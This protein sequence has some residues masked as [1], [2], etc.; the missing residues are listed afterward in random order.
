MKFYFISLLETLKNSLITGLSIFM[1]FIAPIGDLLFFITLLVASDFVTGIIAAK[2]KGE[3]RTSTKMFN[4]I[5]KTFSYFGVLIVGFLFD[6]LT[7][8][9]FKTQLFENMLSI[10]LTQD[11]IDTIFKFKLAALVSFIIIVREFKSIDEN[12]YVIRGW[13]F[14]ETFNQIILKSKLVID[15]IIQLKNQIKQ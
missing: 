5:V 7:V 2:H 11:S 9:V 6:K 12:W 4:S 8:N 10:F 14:F 13:S 15:F 3:L 1:A